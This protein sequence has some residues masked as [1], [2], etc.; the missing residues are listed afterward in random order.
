MTQRPFAIKLGDRLP[1]LRAQLLD[2]NGTA[3]NLTGA[4]VKFGARRRGSRAAVLN[5]STGVSTLG[6]PAEGNVQ[7]AWQD[8]DTA[9]LG[10]GDH[11]GEFQVEFPDGRKGTFPGDGYIPISVR[12]DIAS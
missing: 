8:G 12:R 4:T 6:D 1:V 9:A 7:Y 3:V 10:L 5:T 2:D 11:E